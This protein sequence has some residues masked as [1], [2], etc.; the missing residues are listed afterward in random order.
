MFSIFDNPTFQFYAVF[1]SCLSDLSLLPCRKLLLQGRLSDLK[2]VV[3]EHLTLMSDFLTELK[4]GQEAADQASYEMYTEQIERLT[5]TIGLGKELYTL[6]I[7]MLKR[8]SYTS[9]EWDAFE[10]AHL[11][12][13]GFLLNFGDP[14]SR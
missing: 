7:G 12:F 11:K 13:R 6:T 3:K 10:L 1:N 2:L 4:D 8:R 5:S 14:L 9:Q